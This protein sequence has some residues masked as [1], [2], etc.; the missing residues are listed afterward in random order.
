MLYKVVVRFIRGHQVLALRHQLAAIGCPGMYGGF[1]VECVV[2]PGPVLQRRGCAAATIGVTVVAA[3]ARGAASG[4]TAITL[5]LSL[6]AA[7]RQP[8]RLKEGSCNYRQFLRYVA[9]PAGR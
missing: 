6:A 3:A 1:G 9:V 2:P 5:G 4:A 7:G 8:L